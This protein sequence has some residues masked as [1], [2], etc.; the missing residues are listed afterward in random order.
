MRSFNNKLPPASHL[1]AENGLSLVELMISIT[2]GLLLLAGVTALIAAQSSA[3]KELDNAGRQIENGRYATQLLQEDIQLAGYYGEY[4]SAGTVPGSLPDPCATDIPSLTAAVP[5]PIQGYDLSAT[6]TSPLSCLL[7]ANHVPGTDILVIRRTD[8]TTLPIAS[9]VAGQVYLQ[10]GLLPPS[11]NFDF[12]LGTGSNTSVF[13][14]KKKDGTTLADLRNYLVHI[15]FVSPCNVPASGTTCSGSS[16]DNGHPIPTL[17]R[18]EL[19]VAGGTATFNPTAPVP[20]VEGIEN[21]Q[22][23]YGV[24][25]TNDGSPDSYMTAPTLADWANVMTVRVNLLARNNDTS[26]GYT[27]NKQYSLGAGGTVGPFTDNYKRHVFSQLIRVI[28]PSGR[29]EL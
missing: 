12:V 11:P 22:L 6:A 25:T 20:L 18:L 8:T 17:K 21:L 28:N 27:S 29:R 14:Q 24:D 13:T 23:D 16:D 7:D 26:A 5:F 2:I 19:T 3:R 1:H 15:Y 10:S 9:A 4:A